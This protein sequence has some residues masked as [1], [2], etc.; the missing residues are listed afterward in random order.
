MRDNDSE[1][2][3]LGEKVHFG[4]IVVLLLISKKSC[5]FA[6]LILPKVFT[7]RVLGLQCMSHFYLLVT[8]LFDDRSRFFHL[9]TACAST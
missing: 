4:G 8:L 5:R 3:V 9:N 7:I 2:R 1:V 6:Y